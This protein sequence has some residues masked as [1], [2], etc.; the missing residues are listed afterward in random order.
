MARGRVRGFLAVGLPL[1]MVSMA[2]GAAAQAG[3][4]A[5][6]VARAK[7][8]HERVIALDTHNDI[9]PANFTSERNY[10]RRL[11][12]QVNLPKMLEGGLDA[13][14]FVVYVGQ[15]PLT[16][17]GYDKAYQAALEKFDAI[18]GSP[19]RLRP[20]RSAWRSRR[21]TSAGLRPPAGRWRSSASRTA[22]RSAPT[23]AA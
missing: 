12:T 7:A 11:D 8:I 3:Q 18:H 9:D 20:T 1:L 2:S 22:T 4:D 14:F 15:G 23:S 17:E 19:S 16:P 21:P 10:T 6:L 13:S 5:A